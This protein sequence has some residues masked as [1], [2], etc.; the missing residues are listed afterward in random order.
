M[1]L[2]NYAIFPTDYGWTITRYQHIFGI[3]PTREQ[4]IEVA[5][6]AARAAATRGIASKIS[7]LT[8]TGETEFLPLIAP[9]GRGRGPARRRL[10]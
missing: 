10:H 6:F 1:D 7:V 3:Y 2:A 4:A 8:E 5:C 9:A